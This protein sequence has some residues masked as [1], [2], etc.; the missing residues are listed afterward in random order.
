MEERKT[1]YTRELSSFPV[2]QLKNTYTH[3]HLC[4]PDHMHTY[5]HSDIKL[6]GRIEGQGN[7][8]HSRLPLAFG[9]GLWCT[10]TRRTA[11]RNAMV[12]IRLWFG[13]DQWEHQKGGIM[14]QTAEFGE[15]MF[16]ETWSV[17]KQSKRSLFG[18]S[19]CV[20]GSY[21]VFL[22]HAAYTMFR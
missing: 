7:V 19:R 10:V 21:S 11:R 16:T 3:S 5:M 20:E 13:W 9:P 17:P 15:G 18:M 8:K 4:L 22:V 14:G 1:K 2:R 6:D 12:I